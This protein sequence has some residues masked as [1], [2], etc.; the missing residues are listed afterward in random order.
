[1][2]NNIQFTHPIDRLL[3]EHVYGEITVQR[4]VTIFC[5]GVC[6]DWRPFP[7]RAFVPDP[8]VRYDVE[9]NLR[10]FVL[11]QLEEETMACQGHMEGVEEL[12]GMLRS[13]SFQPQADDHST[14]GSLSLT[15]L[16]WNEQAGH[17]TSSRVMRSRVFDYNLRENGF[18]VVADYGAS[19]LT[20]VLNQWRPME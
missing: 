10:Y 15:V 1:M 11:N 3:R 14:Y 7:T 18:A 13:Y 19:C 5:D 9:N 4:F 6:R 17:L 12:K 20:A 8:R 2:T 16:P